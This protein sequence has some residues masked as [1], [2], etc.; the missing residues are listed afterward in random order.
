MR[1]LTLEEYLPG[2]V[3]GLRVTLS[4]SF[5]LLVLA[6]MMGATS[7]LGYFIKNFADYANY[8][9]VLAGIILVGMVVNVLSFIPAMLERHV[10]RWK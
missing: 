8:T 10:I 9:N 2:V 7:G 1:T 3:A 5:M 4:T 6:E